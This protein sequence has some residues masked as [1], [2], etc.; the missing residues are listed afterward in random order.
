M[1]RRK[2]S[3]VHKRG[4]PLYWKI[5]KPLIREKE[6]R[7]SPAILM[8]QKIIIYSGARAASL[9]RRKI[10]THILNFAKSLSCASRKKI[11]KRIKNCDL[12]NKW[13]KILHRK[14]HMMQREVKKVDKNLYAE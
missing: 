6:M 5:I 8:E 13:F 2:R 9:Q 1:Q 7:E 11:E 12:R 10:T 4:S 14:I 3:C